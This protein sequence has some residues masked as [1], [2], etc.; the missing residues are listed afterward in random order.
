MRLFVN[1]IVR[2]V[3]PLRST[4]RLTFTI[5]TTNIALK[6]R[7]AA[8]FGIREISSRRNFLINFI[9]DKINRLRFTTD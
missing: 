1:Y 5:S 4:Y 6:T 2:R 3:K 8:D 7:I 9:F